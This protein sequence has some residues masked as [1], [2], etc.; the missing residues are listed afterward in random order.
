MI[1]E[2]RWQEELRNIDNNIY[3]SFDSDSGLFEVRHKVPFTSVD[4]RLM[5]ITDDTGQFRRIDYDIIR[6]IRNNYD[7][8]SIYKYKSAT[9]LAD[10]YLDKRE[11]FKKLAEK[12]RDN[13]RID[14]LKDMK[15]EWKDA[16]VKMVDSL[17]QKQVK[18]LKKKDDLAELE[19]SKRPMYY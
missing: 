16:Q 2:E 12:K 14:Q 18:G 8:E 13:D 3:L 9:E 11:Y 15:R 5:W 17:T 7:W 6:Q 1:I 10:Y 19:R 4:R